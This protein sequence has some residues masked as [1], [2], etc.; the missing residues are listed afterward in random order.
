MS[1]RS[2]DAGAAGEAKTALARNRRRCRSARHRAVDIATV[3]VH[4]VGRCRP[5]SAG[6]S[7]GTMP[8][9]VSETCRPR[10]TPRTTAT[11]SGTG[12]PGC[13]PASHRRTDVWSHRTFATPRA[14]ARSTTL[15]ARPLLDIPASSSKARSRM[16]SA[17]G[18]RGTDLPSCESIGMI[19][20]TLP[21]AP[22]A[23]QA[24]SHPR[25]HIRPRWQ[26]SP[27]RLGWDWLTVMTSATQA[28]RAAAQLRQAAHDVAC[29][30]ARRGLAETETV[31][32]NA[33]VC[34]PDWRPQDG[35]G[36]APPAPIQPGHPHHGQNQPRPC[37]QVNEPQVQPART[38]L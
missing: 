33:L 2:A 1:Q 5:R 9:S 35:P 24:D 27:S 21:R 37:G 32:D 11:S 29:V 15:R 20:L 19:S 17:F 23:F 18:R 8:S 6:K 28:A 38:P 30:A 12:G 16:F 31:S 34:T 26:L 10:A 3:S 22:D 13:S 4:V 14:T 7:L 25:A 36:D